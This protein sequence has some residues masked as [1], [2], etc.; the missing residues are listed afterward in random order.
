[1][2]TIILSAVIAY[3][4]LLSAVVQS[5]ELHHSQG[6]LTLKETPQVIVSYDLSVL[7][8][9]HA[10]GISASAVPKSLYQGALQ[11]YQ[12]A[13]VVGTLFEPDYDK[14]KQVK[15]ELIFAGDRSAKAIPQ[16]EKI[17]PVASFTGDNQHY[18]DNFIA[19]NMALAQAFGQQKKAES[20]IEDITTHIKQLHKTNTKQ[21]AAFLFVINHS[22]IPH[23]PGDRFGYI[24]ELTGLH[25]VLSA[26]DVPEILRKRI[27]P[28]SPEFAL[29]QQA[30]EKQLKQLVSAE[31]DWIFVLDRGA[32]NGAE[33][34]AAKTL[35]N[36]ALMNQSKAF[37][38]GRVIY[39]E[40]N[41]W[42]VISGGLH[43][44][45]EITQS[46]LTQMQAKRK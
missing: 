3:S 41:P 40:P 23:V 42:Y 38:Q 46:L 13:P 31:P 36:H 14:L 26:A 12:D 4:A 29:A 24:Y 37:K 16:L 20:Y 6:I 30:R 34:T 7:D 9:L 22:I 18:M 21:S 5:F 11:A 15:P 2:R 33:K 1:M 19:N 28:D 10:L 35:A 32:I 45:R 44:M 27:T 43:N 25:S 8:S 17:A 39:L